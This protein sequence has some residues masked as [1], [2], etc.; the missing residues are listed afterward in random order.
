MARRSQVEH[1]SNQPTAICIGLGFGPSREV[2]RWGSAP[3]LVLL[4]DAR[5]I[6]DEPGG[7]GGAWRGR[8]GPSLMPGD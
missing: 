3:A 8:E 5:I 1:M 2:D 7:H 4:P 6:R